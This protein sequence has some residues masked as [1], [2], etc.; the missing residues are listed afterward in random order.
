MSYDDRKTPFFDENRKMK[1]ERLVAINFCRECDFRNKDYIHNCD[2]CAK[3]KSSLEVDL[4]IP[5]W[6]PLPKTS[7]VNFIEDSHPH[8]FWSEIKEFLGLK[9]KLKRR[10][11]TIKSCH[12]CRLA[13]LKYNEDMLSKSNGKEYFICAKIK[14]I[15]KV[16]ESIPDWCPLPKPDDVDMEA[17]I[18]YITTI[19]W[20]G[21][22]IIYRIFYKFK[23]L[24]LFSIVGLFGL[25]IMTIGFW[26]GESI[27]MVFHSTKP[28]DILGSIVLL[29]IS[30]FIAVR[31]FKAL[32]K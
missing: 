17:K 3:T 30:I 15:K 26:I 16:G 20:S 29:I 7:N 4:Y 21:F 14:P 10:F 13:N 28:L 27:K 18:Y 1:E 32:K 5:Y 23:N 12:D 9:R 24:I 19:S 2:V 6:C 31:I 25:F 11:K 8:N 22:R